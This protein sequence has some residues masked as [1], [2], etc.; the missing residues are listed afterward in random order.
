MTSRELLHIETAFDLAEQ[1]EQSVII[2][3]FQTMS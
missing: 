2:A 1:G 3:S